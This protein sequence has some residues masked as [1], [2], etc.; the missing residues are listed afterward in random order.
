MPRLRLMFLGLLILAVPHTVFAAGTPLLQATSPGAYAARFWP[1]RVVLTYSTATPV[2]VAIQLPAA[3]KWAVLDEKPMDASLLKW[4]KAATS[5]T[6]S[7]PAGDHTAIVGWAG[8]YARPAANQQI[9]VLLDDKRVG[10]L[11]CQFGLEKMQATGTAGFPVGSVRARLAGMMS[12]AQPSLSI[13][14]SSIKSFVSGPTGPQSAEALAVGEA[15]LITLVISAYNLQKPPLTAL[16]LQTVQ[17]ALEPKRLE[18]MPEQGL[19]IEAEDFSNEGLGKVEVST[20]HFDIHGGKCVMGNS[21]D[22]HWLEYPFKLDKPGQYD[23]F[24]RAATQEPFDLRS[25]TIDGKTP[26]G[27][28]LTKFPGTGGWGYSASEWA[29]LQLT[30]LDKAPSLKLD[31]GDHVLRITGEGSTHLNLD[32]LTLVPR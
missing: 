3:S 31:A 7:L 28:G 15:T 18:K 32:Y 6:M 16:E 4:D 14:P 24:I 9:P 2:A 29:A 22:G 30:G 12:S 23:L 11:T 8:S 25:V 21:G 1:D 20:K 13:G 5:A 26:P 19:L 10:T 17:A 27:L